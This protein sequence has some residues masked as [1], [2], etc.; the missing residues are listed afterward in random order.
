MDTLDR[1]FETYE[2]W[3]PSWFTD[4]VIAAVFVGLSALAI[5]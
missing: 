2:R 1:F 5:L 3:I 4:V